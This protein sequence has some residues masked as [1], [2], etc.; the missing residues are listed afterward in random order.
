MTI[1]GRICGEFF[2]TLKQS[3]SAISHNQV[4]RWLTYPLHV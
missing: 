2:N 3:W 4:T 1:L